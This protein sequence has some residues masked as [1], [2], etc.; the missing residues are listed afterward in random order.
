MDTSSRSPTNNTHVIN[1]K[2]ANSTTFNEESSITNQRNE[3]IAIRAP[4]KEIDKREFLVSY[5]LYK[6]MINKKEMKKQHSVPYLSVF[7]FISD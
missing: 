3:P 4:R 6:W 5:V 7:L 2:P 1:D